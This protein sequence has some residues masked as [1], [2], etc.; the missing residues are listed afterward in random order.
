MAQ[1]ALYPTGNN[2]L[3][4]DGLNSTGFTA[5]YSTPIST[6][7]GKMKLNYNLNNKWNLLGTW[8][9]AS[10]SRTGTE[11]ISLLGNP[12]SVAGDP[13]FSN[14]Y[15][16][17]LSGQISPNFLSVT[18]GSFL[19]NWWGWTRQ[20]P[21]P[22]VSGTDAALDFAGEGLGNSTSLT[23]IISDPININTQQA[24]IV[25]GMVTTGTSR[26]TLRMCTIAI[27]SRWV[28]AATSGTT[29]ISVRTTFWVD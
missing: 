22:L 24:R 29:T 13:Y 16:F 21:A 7:V 9:Y 2:T 14:F 28:E 18:H 6:E 12:T 5:D 4:G 10:T 25:F 17:Q 27:P 11:Q 19:K 1:L 3:L 26:R 8:Q 15:T 20:A 23:K